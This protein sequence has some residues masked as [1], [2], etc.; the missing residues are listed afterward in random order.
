[1]DYRKLFSVPMWA[2]LACLAAL[3]LFYPGGRREPDALREARA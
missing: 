2:A 3:L 1:M